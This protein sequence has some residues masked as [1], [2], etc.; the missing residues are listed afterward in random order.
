MEGLPLKV[1][2]PYSKYKVHLMPV[3]RILVSG[4]ATA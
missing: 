4:Q 1:S 3:K 2:E